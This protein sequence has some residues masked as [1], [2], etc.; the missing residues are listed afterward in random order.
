MRLTLRTLLAH[1]DDIL[2][3][4][5]AAQI[6]QK[7]EESEFAS[8]LVHRLK[9]VS[10]RLRLGA[11]PLEG[12]GM[13][14]DPNV[15]AEYLDNTLDTEQVP[16]F[17]KTCLESDVH[18]AEVA[19]SHQILTLV[20][21]E[22]AQV[23]P[24]SRQRMYGLIESS[25]A[26]AVPAPPGVD[27]T[28][29]PPPSKSEAPVAAGQPPVQP[30]EAP[31][32]APPVDP[33]AENKVRRKPEV[34]DYLREGA[35]KSNRGKVIATLLIAVAAGVAI[36][37]NFGGKEYVNQWLADSGESSQ[38]PADETP[39]VGDDGSAANASAAPNGKTP[40]GSLPENSFPKLPAPDDLPK[41]PAQPASV[42]MPK[43]ETGRD[44]I[45]LPDPKPSPVDIVP[46][47]SAAP[48]A[49]PGPKPK[50]IEPKIVRLGQLRSAKQP[51]LVFDEETKQWRRLPVNAAINSGTTL[52]AL[53]T[54]RP[55]ITLG[56]LSVHLG[57]ETMIELEG[58]DEHGVAALRI[59]YGRV[60]LLAAG[61]QES[62]LRVLIGKSRYELTIND[63]DLALHVSPRTTPGVDPA[64]T[65]AA[66]QVDLYVTRGDILWKNAETGEQKQYHGDRHVAVA[67]PRRAEK[68]GL[69]DFPQWIL[70][71]QL[72]SSE[73]RASVRN[74]EPGLQPEDPIQLRLQEM[75][76]HQRRE[77]RLLAARC[78]G[79][80][81]EF[82]SF[83]EAL[84]NADARG[85]WDI[86]V[87][88]L[89]A[90]MARSPRSAKLVRNS[91]KRHDAG[92]VDH[93]YPILWGYSEEG[94][95]DGGAAT[96]VGHLN[97]DEL[98]FRVL[99][100]SMLKRITGL[101]LG[102]SPEDT[103]AKRKMSVRRWTD[104]LKKGA[105]VPKGASL[106]KKKTP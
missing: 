25:E 104:R 12:R 52:L 55:T 1:Q 92:R 106:R 90:A 105:I 103:A 13:G 97:H 28:A 35:A 40:E 5:D 72:T 17:E 79:H 59:I 39:D 83:V 14:L 71:E 101:G 38:Q 68:A 41:E 16:D 44:A 102:Y 6:E 8:G 10:Q 94:L 74:V 61:G 4:E 9:D 86:H 2:E 88:S 70:E 24:D 99:S 89:L 82:D 20:L 53:P 48:D 26:A 33:P 47:D 87:D 76:R 91:L 18:L 45:K 95:R 63:A 23:D 80:I 98:I 42:P 36:F 58:F 85:Y 31:V 43:T 77:I 21:G 62:R 29:P 96:L 7:I 54:F 15:V 60:I 34:P 56:S 27:P 64:E 46:P 84:N 81:D 51:L 73:R 75:A 22:P 49:R 78:L 65:S 93:L 100:S 30:G 32:E 57:S 11:P 66:P 3:P 50:P 19:S 37:L 69:D 67:G